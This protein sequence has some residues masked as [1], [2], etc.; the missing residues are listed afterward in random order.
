[1]QSKLVTGDGTP[2]I[3][4][5]TARGEKI[6]NVSFTRGDYVIGVKLLTRDESDPLR[7]TFHFDNSEPTVWNSTELRAIDLKLENSKLPT[8]H[9]SARSTRSTSKGQNKGVSKMPKLGTYHFQASGE[10]I[11]LASCY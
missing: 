11:V 6:N 9:P 3:K 1:M 5:V 8:P 2:I 7:L 4:K 10:K